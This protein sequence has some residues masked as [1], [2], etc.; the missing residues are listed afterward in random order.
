MEYNQRSHPKISLLCGKRCVHVYVCVTSNKRAGHYR[1]ERKDREKRRGGPLNSCLHTSF[2]HAYQPSLPSLPSLPRTCE[3]TQQA[4]QLRRRPLYSVFDLIARSCSWGCADV[5]ALTPTQY[6]P[7]LCDR[8][9]TL[10]QGGEE[11]R[12]RGGVGRLGRK[13]ALHFYLIAYWD[14]TWGH[15]ILV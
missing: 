8:P 10:L 3:M 4:I 2:L 13:P 5:A 1:R 12:D 11:P 15:T 6:Q 9:T 7:T 14:T